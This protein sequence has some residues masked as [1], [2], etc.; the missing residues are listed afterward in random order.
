M[1][2]KPW[3]EKVF[4]APLENPTGVDDGFY[5]FLCYFRMQGFYVNKQREGYKLLKLQKIK[6]LSSLLSIP[7]QFSNSPV[8]ISLQH[9]YMCLGS[10]INVGQAD[11]PKGFSG[12]SF[13]VHAL[14]NSNSLPL[15]IRKLKHFGK[16]NTFGQKIQFVV[17]YFWY[18][19]IV[20]LVVFFLVSET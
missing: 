5:T 20:Y 19:I 18:I 2:T 12:P 14:N 8:L 9:A 16:N 3:T 11:I 7:C 6:I 4:R 15:T 10:S 13:S 17:F 1:E